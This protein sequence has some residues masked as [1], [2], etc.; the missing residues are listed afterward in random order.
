MRYSDD[1]LVTLNS[2]FAERP[3]LLIL[4]R[5]F[6]MQGELTPVEKEGIALFSSEKLFPIIKKTY[7]PELDLDTP[8]GQLVD[9]WTN[10][11]TRDKGVEGAWLEMAAREKVV[12]YIKGRIVCLVSGNDTG[13][14]LEELAY[15][16]TKSREQNFIDLSA[17]NTII[18]HVD[19]QTTQL[20][21]LA[22]TKRETIQEIQKRLF[23]DSSK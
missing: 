23:K 22:G 18:T 8:L 15:S 3:D 16:H 14:K 10:I 17:R 9:M 2:A 4:L 5:K 19:F 12:D 20:W 7:L 6:F 21:V 1:E 13:L 11:N